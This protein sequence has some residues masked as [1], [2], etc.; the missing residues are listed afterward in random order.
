LL[1][2]PLL[3]AVAVI[4]FGDELLMVRQAG[5]GEEPFWVLPGGRVEPGELITEAVVR[6]VMEET[7]I[8]V[9]DPGR[10][11]FAAQVDDR[12]EN[13]NAVVWTFEVD[14]WEGDLTP[15]D[16]D[17]Y[18]LE[19]A[20][21]PISEACR[22]LSSISWHTLTVRYLQGSLESRPLWLRRVH[23]DGREEWL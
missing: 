14:S 13:W 1:P 5:P 3:I 22:R 15:A 7:G 9:L 8:R 6:E 2:E 20:W 10:V 12:R 18:V 4:R 11:A 17:D 21:V 16:P 19:A 23:P